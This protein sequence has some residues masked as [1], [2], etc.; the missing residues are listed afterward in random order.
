M[1]TKHKIHKNRLNILQISGTKPKYV[2]LLKTLFIFQ[3]RNV[4]Q[5]PPHDISVPC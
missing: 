2:L 1:S 5:K 3:C 4:E